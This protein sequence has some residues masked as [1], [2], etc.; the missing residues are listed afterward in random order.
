[1][2]VVVRRDDLVYPELSYK[3]VGYAYEVFD[4]LGPGHSEKTYQRAYAVMLRRNDHQFGEQVYYPVRFK[5]EIISKGFLDFKVDEKV[6]VELKKDDR[7][8][9]THIDQVLDYIKRSNLK[10]ALLINFTKEGVKFKR[11]VNINEAVA[12]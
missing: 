3:L 11:I 7:F 5:D 2:K 6:I 9:K 12:S 4:E 1:M 8:S 10:L